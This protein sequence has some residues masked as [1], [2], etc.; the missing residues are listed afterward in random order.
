MS[1]IPR[2]LTYA[3]TLGTQNSRMTPDQ[4]NIVR[5]L[6]CEAYVDLRNKMMFLVPDAKLVQLWLEQSDPSNGTCKVDVDGE[7]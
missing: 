6:M 7:T 2:T 5:Q 1:D 4:R 3:L